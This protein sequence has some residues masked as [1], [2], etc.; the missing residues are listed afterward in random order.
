QE[1]RQMLVDAEEQ[2]VKEQTEKALEVLH[3]AANEPPEALPLADRP[4]W[5][6][7]AGWAGVWGQRYPEV[8]GWLEH[9]LDVT[10]SVRAQ[11]S[12]AQRA[13]LGEMAERIRNFLGVSYY[14][15]GQPAKALNHHLRCLAAITNG[16][17]NDP[18]LKLLIYKSL[19]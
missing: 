16:T 12:P 17:V 2:L 8:I 11:A 4:R 9:G 7:L 13:R 6:W 3:V 14:E 19:G 10:N 18:E 5:Y 15:L 1:A